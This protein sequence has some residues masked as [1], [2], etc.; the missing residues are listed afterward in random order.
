MRWRSTSCAH[1]ARFSVGDRLSRGTVRDVRDLCDMYGVTEADKR[2]YLLD[3][4][5]IGK[6]HSRW[7]L[8]ELRLDIY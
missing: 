8:Y 1:G 2:D 4:A 5:R 6:Q 7:N 3:L